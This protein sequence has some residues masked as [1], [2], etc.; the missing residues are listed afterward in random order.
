MTEAVQFVKWIA[1][2]MFGRLISAPSR[3]HHGFAQEFQ[4]SGIP[5]GIFMF[6]MLVLSSILVGMLVHSSGYKEESVYAL[7]IWFSIA[8]TFLLSTVIRAMYW[9]FKREQAALVKA[10]KEEYEF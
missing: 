7:I 4:T 2:K 1:R 8:G 5:F 6:A 10:L 9:A 3:I